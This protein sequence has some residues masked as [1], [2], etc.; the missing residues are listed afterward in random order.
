M[1]DKETVAVV[2]CAGGLSKRMGGVKKEYQKFDSNFSVLGAVIRAFVSV[3]SIKII[4]IAIP[5]ND[6]D[7]ACAAL[8]REFLTA[9]KPKLIFVTGGKTR[10]ESVYNALCALVEHTPSY[11]LIHDGARPWVS[12]SLIEKTIEAAQKHGAAIPVLPLTDTPKEYE[13]SFITRHLKRA[14]T[15]IA[16]TPQG[17]KFTEILQAHEQAAQIDEEFTDDAEVWGRYCGQVAVV[18]GE[19]ENRKITYRGDIG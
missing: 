5:P 9:S 1:S 16:Q 6:E 2:I 17:F 4:A 18:A 7:A 11:V 13:N 19:M 14:N 12:V 10:Q 15:G 3:Y 8:P